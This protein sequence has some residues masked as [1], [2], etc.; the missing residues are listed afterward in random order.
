MRDSGLCHG[1]V[2]YCSQK[3]S[4]CLQL[5]ASWRSVLDGASDSIIVTK[6]ATDRSILSSSSQWSAYGDDLSFNKAIS[7]CTLSEPD[8]LAV[9]L[10][11]S[12]S[13]AAVHFSAVWI[14]A[15]A[16]A[17]SALKTHRAPA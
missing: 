12:A 15:A 13:A 4:Q 17:A 16:S 3:A 1:D 5:D 10:S 2:R 7:P 9:G 14:D 6:R 11:I 8:V